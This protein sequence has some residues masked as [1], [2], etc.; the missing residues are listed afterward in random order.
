MLYTAVQKEGGNSNI[1]QLIYYN[2]EQE[3]SFGH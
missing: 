3:E 1:S 2:M